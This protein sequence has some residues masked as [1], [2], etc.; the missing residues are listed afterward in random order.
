MGT[1]GLEPSKSVRT[2]DLQSGTFAAQLHVPI[3]LLNPARENIWFGL[4]GVNGISNA[5]SK[6]IYCRVVFSVMIAP[7]AAWVLGTFQVIIEGAL[8]GRV[9]WKTFPSEKA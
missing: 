1:E 2:P 7:P 8:C 4:F 9:Y 5:G 3:C 6:P